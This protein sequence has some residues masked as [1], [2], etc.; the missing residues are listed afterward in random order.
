MGQYKWTKK[1]IPHGGWLVIRS[2]EHMY[3]TCEM[4]SKP[5]VSIIDTVT[6]P[7]YPEDLR[8]GTTCSKHME[9]NP[10]GAMR[11]PVNG[12]V[13]V[14]PFKGKYRI[15]VEKTLLDKEFSS[16]EEA[17]KWY[18]FEIELQNKDPLNF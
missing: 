12:Y 9:S 7:D 14:I 8:V 16:T 17:L 11:M 2:E 18:I 1:G 10:N 4:C 13:F 5:G 3:E 6:H 15:R